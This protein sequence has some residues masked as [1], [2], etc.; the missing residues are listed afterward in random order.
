MERSVMNY[1]VCVVGGGGGGGGGL[2]LALR[3]PKKR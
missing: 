3:D 2:K 1:S